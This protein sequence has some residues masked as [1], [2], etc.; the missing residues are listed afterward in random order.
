VAEPDKFDEVL[1]EIASLRGQL[2][3]I[4]SHPLDEAHATMLQYIAQR[5]NQLVELVSNHPTGN[6]RK[7]A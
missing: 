6:Y 5:L 2:E 7:A 4:L 3:E 1:L